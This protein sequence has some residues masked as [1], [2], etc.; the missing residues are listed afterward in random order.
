MQNIKKQLFYLYAAA[1]VLGASMVS[2]CC[3]AGANGY[4]GYNNSTGGEIMSGI[5]MGIGQGLSGL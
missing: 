4:N 5:L 3:T 2:G 1:A